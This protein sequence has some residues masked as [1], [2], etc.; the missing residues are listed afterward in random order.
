M[1]EE[2]AQR[3]VSRLFR[4][5]ERPTSSEEPERPCQKSNFESLCRL[6]R[7][8][9]VAARLERETNAPLQEHCSPSQKRV[10]RRVVHTPATSSTL[11]YFV[12]LPVE[13]RLVEESSLNFCC[14]SVLC[15]CKRQNPG[16]LLLEHARIP[17]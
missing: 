4:R 14:A 2:I 10:C 9:R 13:V 15:N 6:R 1:P 3:T 17:S 16:S 5:A 8:K 7:S 11:G 12:L